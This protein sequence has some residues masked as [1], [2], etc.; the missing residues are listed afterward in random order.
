MP[1]NEVAPELTEEIGQLMVRIDELTTASKAEGASKAE[2]SA[3]IDKA[4]AR[5]SELEA[6]REQRENDAAFDAKV[7]DAVKRLDALGRA[8]SKAHLIG[9]GPAHTS[10]NALADTPLVAIAYMNSPRLGSQTAAKAALEELGMVYAGVPGYS[11]ATVGDTDAAGGYLVPNAVVADITLQAQPGRQVVDLFTVIDG[12]NATSV[13]QPW[14]SAVD[15]RATVVAPGVTKDN[16]NFAVNNYAATFYTI[17]RIFDVGNQLL[18][19]SRGAAERLVR[20]KLAFA[21]AAGEDYYALQGSG[22]SEPLGLLTAIGTSGA[23]VTTFS[24]PSNSTVAGSIPTAIA[25]AAGDLENRGATADGVVM[26]TADWWLMATQGTDTAGFFFSPGLGADMTRGSMSIFG[27]TVR[28]SNRMPSDSLVVGEYKSATFYRG[29]GYRV[30]TST[31]AGDRW[32]KNLTGFR[33]EE[34]IA[35]NPQGAVFTGHFQRIVNVH[36]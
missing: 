25:L 35:F 24:S 27:L 16:S 19:N 9:Q 29:E 36:A 2:I 11:K 5:I 21:F 1:P 34:E 26:N 12:V 7:S 33:G 13:D 18:R 8:P 30:D 28:K 31:E 32:D 3:N 10:D 20:T 23:Y 15:S 6:E 22:T 4:V 17:A 14:E